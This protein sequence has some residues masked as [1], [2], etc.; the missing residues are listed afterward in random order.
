MSCGKIGEDECL[1]LCDTEGCSIVATTDLMRTLKLGVYFFLWFAL[2]TGYNITNKVRLNALPLPWLQSAV[3][4]LTGALFV[5]PLWL[6]GIRKPPKLSGAAMLTLAPIAFCHSLGHVGAVVSASAG[7][8]SFTQI[9]K[10]SEPVFTCGLSALLLGQTVS[11]LTVSRAPPRR[12]LRARA[13][14]VQART[15]AP[16]FS[17]MASPVAFSPPA[18]GNP[19]PHPCRRCR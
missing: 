17:R 12:Q 19:H 10:A 2:S 5:I 18:L 6:T 1:A 16:A 9:V 8:V 4:L 15:S 13:R 14:R 3:S 11:T 7:A